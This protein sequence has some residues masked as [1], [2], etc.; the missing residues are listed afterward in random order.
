MGRLSLAL[1]LSLFLATKSPAYEMT[2]LYTNWPPY[3]DHMQ[4]NQGLAAEAFQYVF[5]AQKVIINYEE[6]PWP[7]VLRQVLDLKSDLVVGIWLN[8]ELTESLIYSDPLIENEIVFISRIDASFDYE[9]LNS[10]DGLFVGRVRD[11]N[12]GDDFLNYRGYFPIETDSFVANARMVASNR[13]DITLE[14][15]V[16]AMYL[17]NREAPELLTQLAFSRTPLSQNGLRIACNK[18]NPRCEPFINDFNSTLAHLKSSG[19]LQ[20]KLYELGL[21]EP[22]AL[23]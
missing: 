23:R 2:G 17:L 22:N 1:C 6:L 18:L 5:D 13:T 19:L 16:T 15:R 8:S 10:L 3:F 14:D 20:K 11:Y 7:R 12:Y 9:G 21:Q 4:P